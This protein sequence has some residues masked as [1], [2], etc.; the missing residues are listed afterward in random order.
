MS[1]HKRVHRSPGLPVVY[2]PTPFARSGRFEFLPQGLSLAEI[3]ARMDVP[4]WFLDHG[5][6]L[7][8]GE[9]VAR[10]WWP[11]VRPRAD[12][13]IMVTLRVRLGNPG[14]G[15]GGQK[16]V[17]TIVATV[18]LIA[19]ATAISYG[20]LGPAGLA[21]LG[22]AFAAGGTGATA[23]A[24]AVTV[25]GSLA[26]H[27]LA[28]PAVKP[29]KRDNADEQR[30]AN[31]GANVIDPDGSVDR[32][33]GTYKVFPKMVAPPWIE[34]V[35]DDEIAEGVYA[36]SGPHKWEDIRVDNV[37]AAEIAGLHVETREGWDNDVPLGMI[38]RYGRMDTPQIEITQHKVDATNSDLLDDHWTPEIDLPLWHSQV[39]R[40]NS[41][42]ESPDEIH[43][44]LLFPQGLYNTLDD[45]QLVTVAVRLRMRIL[46]TSAWINLP[47]VHIFDLRR[48]PIR[49]TIRLVWGDPYGPDDG[50]FSGLYPAFFTNIPNQTTLTPSDVGAWDADASW[51]HG[52]GVKVTDRVRKSGHLYSIFLDPAVFPLGNRWEVSVKRSAAF[53]FLDFDNTNYQIAGVVYSLFDYRTESGGFGTTIAK[54]NYKQVNNPSNC[55]WMRFG[56]LWNQAPVRRPGFA[57]L[58]VRG[59]NVNIQRVSAL[60]S[61]Y[62]RDYDS[63]PG[64]WTKWTTTSN[65]APHFRDVAVGE[66][67]DDPLPEPALDDPQ[68]IAWRTKCAAN[69]WTADLVLSGD[70]ARNALS[71]LASCG[72]ARW[73]QADK[74]SVV[75]DYDRSAEA[76][77]QLFTPINSNNFR[78]EKVLGKRPD[79]LILNWIDRLNDYQTGRPIVVLRDGVAEED[80][81]LFETVTVEKIDQDKVEAE[82]A[83]MLKA[84]EA[85]DIVYYGDVDFEGLIARNGDLVGIA[86]DTVAEHSQ[87]ARITAINLNGGG[88]VESL[89]LDAKVAVRWSEALFD[90]ADL[91]VL[92]D[93]FHAGENTGAAIQLK[94]GG[95]RVE[96]LA[97][98]ATGAPGT[99]VQTDE[100]QTIIF[101]TPFAPPSGLALDRVV[102]IGRLSHERIDLVIKEI[103][104][105][106]DETATLAML[107]VANE[108][109]A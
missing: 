106:R 61:G 66:L 69:D 26:I 1:G 59:L 29:P 43:L 65:P 33:V 45:T 54:I 41:D 86:H 52:A 63:G 78:W 2:A 6:I 73:Y 80:A 42:G 7:I 76:I 79:G 83:Y 18:A 84:R 14:G 35:K 46:G 93:L 71:R 107:D 8:N 109:H 32:V 27:A 25:I 105:G 101:A 44:H 104:R 91:F 3:A 75:I 70:D 31:I 92:S 67:V 72:R 38:Q 77:T 99:G 94:H 97:H 56:C 49:V 20:A 39:T 10:Q 82:G 108:I 60:A 21:L 22:P 88:N 95:V 90:Q 85:R 17:A 19:A 11:H 28:L 100:I 23:T 30:G 57:L 74:L 87:S 89:D 47:E 62:V 5:E 16:N 68:M 64:T 96:P 103:T 37:P 40:L 13:E 50:G 51:P 48:T 98:G 81:A 34:I 24:L 55:V 36:L 4:G 102:A 9:P 12:R 58:G 15:G 53:K